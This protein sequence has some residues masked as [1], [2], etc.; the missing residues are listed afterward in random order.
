[1]VLLRLSPIPEL[2]PWLRSQVPLE[3]VACLDNMADSHKDCSLLTRTYFKYDG[4]NEA[5]V[6][7]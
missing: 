2:G 7:I 6:E 5:V 4:K 1:M 3:A